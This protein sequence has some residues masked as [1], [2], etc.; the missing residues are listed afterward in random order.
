M[1]PQR[2]LF[3]RCLAVVSSFLLFAPFCASH[4]LA[5]EAEDPNRICFMCHGDPENFSGREG[6]E[7]LIVTPEEFENCVHCGVGMTC[8]T[9]HTDYTYPH[10]GEY[11]PVDCGRCHS[12][13]VRE[14]EESAHGYAL[15]RG[16]DR[17]PTCAGCHGVHE[18]RKSDDPESPTFH[19]HIAEMCVQC[20]ST[21]GLLTD[22]YVRLASPEQ[23]YAQSVHGQANGNGPSE[24]ATCTD[25]HGVHDLKGHNDPNSR[26]N[27]LNVSS[28]CGECHEAVASEY[29]RSIHGRALAAGVGDSPT[30]TD[31]HG[32]HLILHPDD[33]DAGTH[34]GRLATQVC[35]DCHN[36]PVI[37]A[38]YGLQEEVVL[39]YSDSYHGWATRRAS[40]TSA[41]CVS[42]H[43]AHLILPAADPQS[44]VAAGNVV[45]TCAQCH[46]G[47]T[48]AF[49]ES[50]NHV[51]ASSTTNAG[52]R[53][54]TTIYI[55]L[56]IFVIGG[57][58]LHNAI[59]F[60][61]YMV[62]KR[63]RDGAERGFLRFDR[64]QIAQHATLAITFIVLVITGFALRYPEAGWVRVTGLGLLAEPVRSTVHRIAGVGLV[65]FSFVH[66]LYIIVMRRGRDEFIAMTP[67]ARDAKDFVDNM[68]FYTWR[69]PLRARFGRYDYT[70]KA[71]YWALVWGTAL[72]AFT[73]VVLWFPAL[74]TG[75]F[76]TWIVSI[77][78]T[79]HFYEAWLATLAIVVWHF[80]FVMIHPEVYPMSWIWLTGNMPEHEAMAV[81]GRW[82]DEELADDR[83][84]QNG[85]SGRED[86]PGDQA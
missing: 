27:R 53:I 38:K 81:H 5:Q 54:V 2:T 32:E 77:S 65:L 34:S 79:V 73:G 85:L 35:G 10:P 44:S 29:D 56:I 26:I 23:Q 17:A 30:C 55:S 80:F 42:C 41:T 86:S 1:P 43:T 15:S 22:Q 69:S 31:C 4:L 12:R 61:Y 84:V 48:A 74:A 39:S 28:T 78:E 83:D 37:I 71:E 8:V 59:I 25:C 51:A 24:A 50:Y 21:G 18:I 72:M 16:N 70:Q 20:H 14:Y 66:V 49:A 7:R 75:L 62:E 45:A 46:E 76:P 13:L 82:Y 47:A 6:G 60:N 52:R 9:C 67:N 64:I 33:P 57:M 3:A 63:R 11:A 68:R 36:D 19:A 58:A 40:Q